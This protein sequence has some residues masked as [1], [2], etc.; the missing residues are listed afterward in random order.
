[1]HPS[2][3]FLSHSDK[4][5]GFATKISDCLINHGIPVWYSRT[6]I[7][8]ARQWHDEI[9]SALTRCDAFVVILSPASVK[10]KWVKRELLFALQEDR[11]ENNIVPL[12]FK[13]CDCVELS[14]TL[15]Q[16]EFVDFT[17]GFRQGCRD[18]LRIW[19]V[20]YR[21]DPIP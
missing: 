21:G 19:G 14:W 8:G 10:S 15:P 5:R 17:K 7:V 6:S 20:G 18:L 9:G 3:I 2:E 12:L 4:D 16:F 11:Y 13:P 1:M